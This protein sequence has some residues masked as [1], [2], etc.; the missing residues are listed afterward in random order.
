ME[1]EITEAKSFFIFRANCLT[2]W[3]NFVYI[4]YFVGKCCI[5][6]IL[7]SRVCF[8]V[9][10]GT[11]VMLTELGPEFKVMTSFKLY[12]FGCCSEYWWV[13]TAA[14]HL[15]PFSQ[16]LASYFIFW[17]PHCVFPLLNP[18]LTASVLVFYSLRLS[19]LLPLVPAQPSGFEAEAELDSRIMLSWLWPVQDS[20]ISFELLYWEANN[21]GD[22]VNT[23]LT[24][25]SFHCGSLMEWILVLVPFCVLK[26]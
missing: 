10:V 6:A 25:F 20:I 4:F 14:F 21:P 13:L 17:L 7:H 5:M 3:I 16:C 2:I 23:T 19:F 1:T 18:P 22:K 12:Q 9:I 26:G 24:T 15:I 8:T 11:S